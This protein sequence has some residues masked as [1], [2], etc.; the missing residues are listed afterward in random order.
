MGCNGCQ[1]LIGDYGELLTNLSITATGLTVQ[2][3][4]R[5]FV[6]PMQDTIE[7]D[8]HVNV[9]AA[10]TAQTAH[11]AAFLLPASNLNA[12]AAWSADSHNA[13]PFTD[14]AA[15]GYRLGV[16]V[17]LEPDE[18]PAGDWVLGVNRPT[19]GN[20]ANVIA[21]GITPAYLRWRR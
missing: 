4:A 20:A 9:A 11:V 7:I 1:E 6:P 8:A 5:I 17:V 14:V 2:E 16:G 13:I 21:S 12:L 19:T 3:V 18:Y 15:F 10:V